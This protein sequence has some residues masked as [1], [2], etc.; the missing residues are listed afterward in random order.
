MKVQD[1]LPIGSIV[2]LNNGEKKLM[3]IGIMQ[4]DTGGTKKDYD[5]LG[6]L[7]PE[8]HIGEGFQYLFNHEDI[9]KIIFRGYEDE[10]RASFI[11]KLQDLYESHKR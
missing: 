3:I 4:N 5:Y 10:E 1:L 6:E 2:L 8:G 7:Y 9:N 11:G